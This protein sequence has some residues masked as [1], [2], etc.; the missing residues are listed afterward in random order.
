M[1][2]KRYDKEVNKVRESK[3]YNERQRKR[4][5]GRCSKWEIEEFC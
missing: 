3:E 1:K 5:N 4:Q 2:K